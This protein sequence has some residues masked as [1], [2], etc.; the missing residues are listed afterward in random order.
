MVTCPQC[1]LQLPS[2]ARFCARC[3]SRLPLVRSVGGAHVWVLVLFGLG[4]VLGALVALVYSVIAVTPDLPASGLDP[5]RVRGT[6][7]GLAV[8]GAGMCVLQ[9]MAILGLALGRD[10]GRVLATIACVAWSLTCIGLP[11]SLA[12]ISSLWARR[13]VPMG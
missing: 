4:A 5:A 11:V 6:A 9:L 2:Y 1:G 12:V 7:I 8:V 13:N 3:S 10:W